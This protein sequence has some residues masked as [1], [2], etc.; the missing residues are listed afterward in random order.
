M[1]VL[2]D[3]FSIEI[4][5]ICTYIP[6][7]SRYLKNMSIKINYLNKTSS[8]FSANLVLFSNEK[9]NL[10]GLKNYLS[11]SEFSYINDLLRTSDLKK[12]LLVF[13]LSSKKI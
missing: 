12:N 2:Y 4:W 11:N 13:E 1:I 10:S 3:E 5:Y 6:H 7:N 9:F 8:S